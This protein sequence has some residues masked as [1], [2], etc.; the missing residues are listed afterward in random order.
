MIIVKSKKL[1]DEIKV[2]FTCSDYA[3]K[4]IAKVLRVCSYLGDVGASRTVSF[5]F[6]GDGSA[7]LRNVEIEDTPLKK[8]L[9]S[10]MKDFEFDTNKSEIHV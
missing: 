2:S 10:N 9:E 3:L 8:W 5:G 6:D 7:K 4:T 1:G